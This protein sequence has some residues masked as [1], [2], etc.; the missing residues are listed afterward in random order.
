MKYVKSFIA[1]DNGVSGTIGA[2]CFPAGDDPPDIFFVKTPVKSEQNY[3]KAKA[4]ITRIHAENLFN[5]LKSFKGVKY[6]KVII[7]RPM[8]NPG[9]FKATTSALRA[10]EATLIVL[11][12]LGYGYAYVDSKEWQT[13][14]LPRGVKGAPALKK[15]SL[16]I[17]VR[18]YPEFSELIRKHKD[19][20]GLLMAHYLMKTDKG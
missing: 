16:D 12:K 14:V 17:G 19:A 8:V 11:E 2:F 9:R 3:T 15:A 20:D 18:L 13:A 1:I 7:E 10:L 4:N 6:T 5:L